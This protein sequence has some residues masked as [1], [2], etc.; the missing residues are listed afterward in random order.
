MVVGYGS[1]DRIYRERERER[2]EQRSERDNTKK[3]N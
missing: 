3:E 1:S 2:M